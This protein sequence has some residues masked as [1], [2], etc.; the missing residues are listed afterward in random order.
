MVD[1][2]GWIGVGY[3]T[4]SVTSKSPS[5]LCDDMR[6][7]LMLWVWICKML[8]VC[9]TVWNDACYYRYYYCNHNVINAKHCRNVW[10]F[11]ANPFKDAHRSRFRV[12]YIALTF[13][14]VSLPFQCV[15]I[16]NLPHIHVS[17][18]YPNMQEININLTPL[19][20]AHH[21]RK[22]T[23]QPKIVSATLSWTPKTTWPIDSKLHQNTA[24]VNLKS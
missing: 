4:H 21:A 20:D 15:I 1:N 19:R 23:K 11:L 6:R 22:P 10:S 13:L 24:L 17:N 9:T 8:H 12:G 18:N 16:M 5:G 3:N 14:H 7:L 2:R